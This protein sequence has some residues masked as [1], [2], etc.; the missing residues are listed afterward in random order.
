[1]RL[2]V[3][4]WPSPEVVDAVAA[5][6][7]PAVPGL[8]WTTPDQWHVTLRFLGEVPAADV[9]A[10]ADALPGGAAPEVVLGPVTTVLGAEVL[11]VPVDGLDHLAAAVREATLALVPEV[12]RRRFTGHLTL[13][14]AARR[15][16]VPPELVGGPLAGAWR[17]TRIS[18]VRSTSGRAGARYEEVEG[19][20]LDEGP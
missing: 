15:S 13:A 1:V 10:V 12:G 2:F 11:V 8:R 3:A 9:G 20:D 6:E 19:R 18:L 16:R 4:V 17:A 14:R 7:R 5:F